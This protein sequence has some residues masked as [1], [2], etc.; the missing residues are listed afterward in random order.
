MRWAPSA[1]GSGAASTTTPRSDRRATSRRRRLGGASLQGQHD[2]RANDQGDDGER[3]HEQTDGDESRGGHGQAPG[4]GERKAG[5]GIAANRPAA[6]KVGGYTGERLGLPL[7]LWERGRS[8]RPAG[9][10]V[11]LRG[12]G[13]VRPPARRGSGCASGRAGASPLNLTPGPGSARTGPSPKGRGAS[14]EPRTS[15]GRIVPRVQ[16]RSGAFLPLRELTPFIVAHRVV[17]NPLHRHPPPTASPR[18]YPI[19]PPRVTSAQLAQPAR[20]ARE[21]HR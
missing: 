8:R 14:P 13:R 3:Q 10:G 1:S 21:L 2:R 11:W 6:V 9:T 19:P 7:S 4:P 18:F 17:G 15:C 5:K 16:D 20:A 12:D